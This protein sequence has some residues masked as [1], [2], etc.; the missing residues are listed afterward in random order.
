MSNETNEEKTEK[1]TF[2]NL[3]SLRA[4][5]KEIVQF[6]GKKF[7][8]SY[9]PCGVSIPILEAHNAQIQKELALI[10]KKKEPDYKEVLNAN[11]ELVSIFCSFYEK[12]FTKE[13][14]AKN[15]TSESLAIMYNKIVQAIVLSFPED[16]KSESDEETESEDKKKQTGASL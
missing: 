10:E 12:E 4:R 6:L 9:I 16:E 7:D 5:N 3:D 2:I 14:I 1:N 15:A 8:L 13:Y 11:I